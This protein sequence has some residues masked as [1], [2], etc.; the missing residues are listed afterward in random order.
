MSFLP[1]AATGAIVLALAACSGGPG[2]GQ[3]RPATAVE[4]VLPARLTFHTKVAAFGQLAA[5][6][7]NALSL[8]LPQA[9]EVIAT[10]VIAGRRVRRGTPLLKLATDPATRSAY[11]QAQSALTV[12]RDDLARSQRLHAEKLATNAQLDAARKALLD[13]QAALAAQAKLGGAE[14]VASLRA[15]S[16]GVVTR[17][18]VQRGQRTAAGAPLVEFAPQAALAAQ[19]GVEPAAA[20]G[21][22]AGMPVAIRPVYATQDAPPLHATVAM[23]GDAVDPQTH[24]VDVVATFDGRA[25]LAAGSALSASIDTSGFEAWAV[26]RDALQS[27]DQGDYVFQ[28][29]R[30][31]AKRVAVKV[32]APDGSPIGVEGALDPRAPVITVGSYE[33]ADGDPVRG[34]PASGGRGAAAR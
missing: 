21:I 14:A 15:P 4:A 13:A 23:V 30:G 22:R 2:G 25:Q 32:L 20:A 10:D 26:P 33:L 27:D 31:K 18:D 19:L 3:A 12:A 29:E 8:S 9:G 7:R 34:A 5:D 17:L 6:S 28:I 16:D 24:L 1:R 11:L